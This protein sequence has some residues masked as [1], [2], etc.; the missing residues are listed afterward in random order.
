METNK[1]DIESQLLLLTRQFLFEQETERAVYAVTLDASLERQL[2]IDSL[3]KV[4]LFHRIEKNFG[5]NFPDAVMAEADTLAVIADAVLVASP[6]KKFFQKQQQTAIV[7]E[8]VEMDLSKVN[9]LHEALIQYA[10]REPKRPH[11]YFQDEEGNEKVITYGDLL[12]KASK[13]ANGLIEKGFK[14]DETVAIMLPTSVEFFQTFIGILLAGGI[15][16]PV[17]PPFRMDRLEEYAI[18]EAKILNNAQVRFLVTFA[19]AEMLSKLL[20]S[21]IPSLKSV[22][23]AENLSSNKSALP[24]IQRNSDDS[25]LLQ[26]SSGSTGDPKGILLCHKNII[27]N[28]RAITQAIELK[29]TDLAVSWLPLYHDMGLMSWIVSLYLG[30]PITILSPISFL[31]RPER[32]LWAIHYHRGT[33]SAAPNFAY[34]LCVKKIDDSLLEGLD[35]S[36]WRLCFN[37]AEAVNIN[38]LRRFYNRFKE[39]GLK[40]EALFPVYG[41]AENTVALATPPINREFR[42]DRIERDTFEK[43]KRAV[44]TDRAKEYLEFASEGMAIPGHAIRIVNEDIQELAE[45]MIGNVQF[46][47][48]SAMR[49][50]Y[51]RPE[52]TAAVYHDGWWDTGDLG[53]I[54]DGELFITGRKKDLIIKAGRNIY[55]ETIEE[56]VGNIPGI[57]KGCAI[58]FGV[59][60]AQLG[61][62]KLIIVAESKQEHSQQAQLIS[63][64]TEQVSVNVGVPPDQVIIVPLRN[65]PKTS[66]GKLQRSACKQAY[67]NGE[68]TKKSKTVQLQMAKLFFA[69]NTRRGVRLVGKSMRF[70]Y[71]LYVWMV[72]ALTVIPTWLLVMVTPKKWGGHFIKIWARTL[73]VLIFCRI[74]VVNKKHLNQIKPIIYAANH[75]SYTDSLVL[76][77]VLPAGTLFIAKK[78]VFKIPLIAAAVKKLNYISVDRWE[79]AQNIEDTKNIFKALEE[80]KSILIFP[81]GTFVY[82]SGLRP[83]KAGA[84]QLAVD[85]RVSICPVALQNTRKLLRGDSFLLSP[86]K[87]MV[88]ICELMIPKENDWREITRLKT[89]ARKIISEHC[90]EPTVDLI[91]AGPELSS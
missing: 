16:V 32:W 75:G 74:K 59:A 26:Y 44:P 73:F 4:E 40:K 5:V 35:L 9:T 55:P 12:T 47:G 69:A 29:P 27:A 24:L 31:N 6:A 57:R 7:L 58:A 67:L 54:A 42:V 37:G 28:I 18:R 34:E 80:R 48:P 10:V 17:Y 63:M 30:I 22:I 25:A 38:T 49:G 3:G 82:A 51:N 50:Y 86:T 15:P 2:G 52:A 62:E 60:D 41:L 88:T 13:I 91:A 46:T 20:Q 65:I 45:R 56:V 76:L 68:I 70:L 81:E 1:A 66:S 23:T 72:F 79:F 71:T 8:S 84:F 78:E 87:I 21:Y 11:I 83:F 36:S 33:V 89:E 39:Y 14:P 85:S 53:Y 19:K 90:G 43:N 61:T 77:A 64:I